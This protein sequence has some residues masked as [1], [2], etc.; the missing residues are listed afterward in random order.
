MWRWSTTW[1]TRV[2]AIANQSRGDPARR[3]VRERRTAAS[4]ITSM[5]TPEL[6]G[7]DMYSRHGGARG[8]L[9]LQ[10]GHLP[11]VPPE[12]QFQRDRHQRRFGQPLSPPR[13][14]GHVRHLRTRTCSTWLR[15]IETYYAKKFA[16]LTRHARRHPERRRIDAARQ[17]RRRL[18]HGCVGRLCP[19]PEQLPDHSSRELRGV[20][21]DGLDHQRREWRVPT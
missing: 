8:G 14:R 1:G 18:D 5:V 10:P 4:S 19:Q 21:Q 15:T 6:D 13:Q 20:F 9:Q 16:K 7:A 11:E 17:Q 12:L 3:D 2:P